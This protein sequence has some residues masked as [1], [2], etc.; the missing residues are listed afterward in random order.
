[1]ISNCN[2]EPFI[3]DFREAVS[4]EST[5]HVG[6]ARDS[7]WAA[8]RRW[9]AERPP[10]VKAQDRWLPGSAGSIPVRCYTPVGAD[11]SAILYLHGGGWSLGDLDSHDGI[12]A[13]LAARSQ[14]VVIAVHYRR[15]PEAPFPAPL[16]DVWS[17]WV[18][19]SNLG[20]FP[21]ATCGDS[22]GGS[23]AA[24]LSLLA[25]ERANPAPLA[26]GLI[27][28]VLWD[29]QE[30]GTLGTTDDLLT[31]EQVQESWNL[32]WSNSAAGSLAMA[33]PGHAADPGAFAPTCILHG[34]EDPL[35]PGI[36]RFEAILG[37]NGITVKRIAAPG[38]VHGSLHAH[39]HIAFVSQAWRQ[40]VAEL[41]LLINAR[42]TAVRSTMPED[43]HSG[44]YDGAR[45]G[46]PENPGVAIMTGRLPWTRNHGPE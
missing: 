44:Q 31:P 14:H 30:P 36:E 16:E 33:A 32:Y 7:Y 2:L 39:G 45:F 43:D 18:S 4:N 10:G 35:T 29:P 34:P 41:V 26:Q 11:R 9:R 24:A 1:M 8:C 23:L 13:D 19:L 12:A 42:R 17:V 3:R 6:R 22:A 25:Y 38:L 28:P 27:Y 5:K 37:S 20:L 21:V 40:F 46:P 15:T